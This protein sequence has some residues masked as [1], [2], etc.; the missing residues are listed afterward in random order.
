MNDEVMQR[1]LRLK[2]EQILSVTFRDGKLVLEFELCLMEIEGSVSVP[3]LKEVV[4]REIDSRT[5]Q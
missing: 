3:T 2:G 1:I 4:Q 5:T